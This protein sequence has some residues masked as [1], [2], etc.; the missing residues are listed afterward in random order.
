LTVGEA[1]HWEAASLTVRVLN[2][3]LT[4][5]RLCDGKTGAT[6]GKVYGPCAELDA[7]YREEI[8]GVDEEI[9]ERMHLFFRARWLYSLYFHTEAL[10]SAH[11][12]DSEFTKDVP[13]EGAIDEF[14]AALEKIATTPGCE[15]AQADFVVQWANLQQALATK[16]HDKLAFSKAACDMAPFVWAKTWLYKFPAI[17]WAAM[18][19]S[20][21]S[22]SAS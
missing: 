6:L 11:L 14:H 3:A 20:A 18:R 17:Q 1:G 13:N 15:W 2:P 8:T 5:L 12:L 9:R 4:V 19:L 16:T 21:L 22:C 7:L 10:T